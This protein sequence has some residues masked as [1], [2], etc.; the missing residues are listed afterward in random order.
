MRGLGPIIGIA[1]TLAI[2]GQLADLGPAAAAAQDSEPAALAPDTIDDLLRQHADLLTEVERMRAQLERLARIARESRSDDLAGG[3][4]DLAPLFAALSSDDYAERNAATDAMRRSLVDRMWVFIETPD[5]NLEARHRMKTLLVETSAMIRLTTVAVD[6][7]PVDRDALWNLLD[8]RADWALDALGDDPQRIR[9]AL[10]HPP[11]GH[12]FAS[13]VI[14]ASLV[15]D[16]MRP[17]PQNIALSQIRD[18][19]SPMLRAA[20]L[21]LLER[22]T[23]D[24]S[25]PRYLPSHLRDRSAGMA[26]RILARDPSGDLAER[27]VTSLRDAPKLRPHVDFTIIETL[28]GMQAVDVAPALLEIAEAKREKMTGSHR[29]QDATIMPGDAEMVGAARLLGMDLSG[30]KVA[31]IR[32]RSERDPDLYGFA[33]PPKVENPDRAVAFQAVREAAERARRNAWSPDD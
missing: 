30:L 14:L 29:Y 3:G 28:V 23:Q 6:L 10:E 4:G 32:A 19:S 5:L 18:A 26:V 15:R 17:V 7:R 12:L 2:A 27:L 13:E 8:S 22:S 24:P 11:A 21:S 9:A 1:I 25:G 20:L 33:E 16:E 31:S